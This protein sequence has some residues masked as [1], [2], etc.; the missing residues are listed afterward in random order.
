[1]KLSA[2]SHQQVLVNLKT[3]TNQTKGI[4]YSPVKVVT[5]L[6]PQRRAT[7]VEE[8]PVMDI[9]LMIYVC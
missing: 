9:K 6:I 2:Y 8:T 3:D 5:Q 7:S 1:M 4:L